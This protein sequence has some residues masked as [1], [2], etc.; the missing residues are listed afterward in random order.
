MSAW[1]MWRRPNK[2][3]TEAAGR[4]Y[5]FALRRN[6]S[7]VENHRE[8]AVGGKHFMFIQ[9][10]GIQTFAQFRFRDNSGAQN[11]AAQFQILGASNLQLHDE[12]I[13]WRER[14]GLRDFGHRD[15]P[16]LPAWWKCFRDGSSQQVGV[17]AGA[18]CK[19]AAFTDSF[20]EHSGE[21]FVARF[22]EQVSVEGQFER[23]AGFTKLRR[24]GEERTGAED[25]YS[26]GTS[27]GYDALH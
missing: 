15:E 2:T 22:D 27:E 24:G 17:I 7:V 23:T 25:R 6:N 16:L 26:I 12:K 4:G 10:R 13:H 19:K 20:V 11:S 1:W 21:L 5:K 14:H 18:L 3:P 9:R 8:I